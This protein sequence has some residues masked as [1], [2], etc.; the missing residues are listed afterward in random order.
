MTITIDP[1]LEAQLVEK[2][3]AEGLTVDAYI[4]RLIREENDWRELREEPLSES[5]PEFADIRAAVQEG[6]EQAERGEGRAATEVFG[7]LRA[8]HG[9]PG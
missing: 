4:A 8:R 7:E 2:A 9:I 1:E 5:V 3:D 6:L